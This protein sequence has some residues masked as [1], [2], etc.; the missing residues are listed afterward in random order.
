MIR[1]LIQNWWLLLVRGIFAL[2]FA[3]SIF[4][5]L[6]FVPAPLLRELAFAGLTAIFALLAITTGIIT[7]AAAVY[8][9][10]KGGSAWLL[11]ADGI[12][13]ACG[14][15]IIL[16][17]PTMTLAHVIQLIAAT[18]LLAGIL[19]TAAGFHVQRH[20]KDEW[21]LISCGLISILFTGWLPFQRALSS[22]TVLTWTSLYAAA[23]G[24]TMVGFSLRLRNLRNSIHSLA[25]PTA[26]R[27][28][29]QTGAA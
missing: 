14:G 20:I 1:L 24:L 29:S 13:V 3:I 12:A 18:S 2:V 26:S 23:S 22:Q 9:A 19:E 27:T 7:I 25:G 17:G 10:E 4:A 6:P 5:L 11:L 15:F 8:R 21:F 16:L 28:K